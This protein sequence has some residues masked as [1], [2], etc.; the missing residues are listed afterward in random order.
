MVLMMSSSTCEAG[1][2]S[3]FTE[4]ASVTGGREGGAIVGQVGLRN[5]TIV[6]AHKLEV[7]FGVESLVSVKMGL[8]LDVNVTGSMVHK[9]ASTI[10]HLI[11]AR[12]AA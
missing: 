3:K 8:E 12:L 9:K 4:L 2:L 11:V 6:T 10:K 1:D 5:H 7:L